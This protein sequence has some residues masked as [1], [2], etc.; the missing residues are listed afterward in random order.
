MTQHKCQSNYNNIAPLLNSID[1]FNTFKTSHSRRTSFIH[2]PFDS[3]RYSNEIRKY[4][5]SVAI[6]AQVDRECAIC[7]AA[8]CCVMFWN[9]PLVCVEWIGAVQ[10]LCDVLIF[11]MT[12]ALCQYFCDELLELAG[13]KYQHKI[14]SKIN[15]Q[16]F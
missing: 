13:R 5:L 8:L 10:Y 9:P 3:V 7:R 14:I 16:I 6:H 11:W 4:R 15:L 2:K 12:F 1:T